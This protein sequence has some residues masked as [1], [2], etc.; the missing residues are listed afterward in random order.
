MRDRERVSLALPNMAFSELK[1]IVYQEIAIMHTLAHHP[2]IITLV[3]FT[4]EPLSIITK[5]YDRNLFS[6]VMAL[7]TYSRSSVEYQA[8]K[9]FIRQDTPLGRG[10]IV[11]GFEMLPEIAMHIAF[12]IASGMFEMHKYGILHR[13]LKSA[14]VLMEFKPIDDAIKPLWM[15]DPRF[16]GLVTKV[17]GL[18]E[19]SSLSGALGWGKDPNGRPIIP[20][21]PIVCDF[22][23]AKVIK[24]NNMEDTTPTA[25]KGMKE[26]QAVGIS[27]RY[28]APEAFNR[29]YNKGAFNTESKPVDVFAFAVM[30]WEL[31]E[32]KVPFHKITNKEVESKIKS[33]ERPMISPKFKD[34]NKPPNGNRHYTLLVK[35]AEACW[36]HNPS[37]RPTFA[38]L[39]EKLRPF[40]LGAKQI[41]DA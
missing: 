4:E 37:E 8:L 20:I 5:L 40:W 13:D 15:K 39:K 38:E 21:N 22:G 33:G 9:N 36:K 14:N 41:A 26:A 31:F 24:K 12:G 11:K 18:F 7:P 35:I 19:Q 25:V 2:N 28:A 29:M 3:G 34:L 23:L 1:S 27:Y 16:S 6:L 30:V 10:L 17:T 32:R